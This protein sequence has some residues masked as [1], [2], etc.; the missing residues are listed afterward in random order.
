MTKEKQSKI[1]ATISSYG[2]GLLGFIKSRVQNDADAEDILQ[3]VWFQFS[4]LINTQPVEQAGAWLY[5][6]AKN[7]IVDKQRKKTESL[8]K[9]SD[10]DKQAGV[11]PGEFLLIADSDPETAYQGHAVWERLYSALEELPAAQR[12]VFIWHELENIPFAE[13]AVRTGEPVGKLVMRKRY[14]VLH[15]RKR[16]KIFYDEL[17]T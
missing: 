5:R 3:D 9:T 10:N 16:L 14:A 7:R 11:E 13:I 12:D 17:T 2:K 1:I 6:V 15:L 8:W 4:A